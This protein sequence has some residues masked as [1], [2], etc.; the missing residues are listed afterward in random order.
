MNKIYDMHIHIWSGGDPVNLI[1]KFTVSGVYG[2]AVFSEPPAEMKMG[3]TANGEQRLAQVVS[4]CKEYPDRLFPVL[5]L[6][7]DEKGALSLVKTAKNEGIRG[8]KIICNS[9]YVYESKSMELLSCIAEA[10]LPICFHSGILWTPG[11]SGEFNRPLNWERLIEIPNLRFSMAHCSWPWY[12][13]CLSLY[14]KFLYLSNQ[15]DFSTEMYL[16]L[17]P[18]TPPSYRRDLLTK[19]MTSGYDIDHHIMFGVDCD[20]GNYSVEWAQKWIKMDNDIFDDL[21]LD[22]A[23]KNKIF[24]ENMLRFFGISGEKHRYKPQNYDGS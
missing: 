2:G 18:G 20:A 6:H 9:F 16:D 24:A 19:L 3:H 13:E 14:G 8:F 15:K 12:D 11:V 23:Q 17:T 10:G 5:W 22:S 4:F 1:E 7:P 21:G